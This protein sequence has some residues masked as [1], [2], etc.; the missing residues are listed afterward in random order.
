MSEK[1]R[2]VWVPQRLTFAPNEPGADVPN[3][4]LTVDVELVD[5]L[6]APETPADLKAPPKT[7][8]RTPSGLALLVLQKGT[9]TERVAMTSQVRVEFSGWTR[10]GVLF[11][12]TRLS[13][14][15]ATFAVGNVIPGWNEALQQMVVG[16][17]VRIWV[18]A[19]LA[20]GEKPRRRGVPAG[21]LVYDMELLAL[22]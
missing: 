14:H 21:D 18:P 4:D 19:A 12:S 22:E 6:I 10:D 7:A 20:Y 11:E 1:K 17:K 15:P 2:R 9:G 8:T 3:V 16:E 13:G 5:I